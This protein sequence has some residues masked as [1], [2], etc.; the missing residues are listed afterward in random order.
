MKFAIIVKS[1]ALES[2][3]AWSAA[4]FA[5]AALANGHQVERIFFYQAAV[6]NGNAQLQ[7]PQGQNDCTT[8]WQTLADKG[9]ELCLCISSAIRRGVMDAKEAE[10]YHKQ[11]TLHPAFSIGGLGQLIDAH[12]NADRVITFQ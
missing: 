11:S 9:V 3:G 5:H 12:A 6:L 8:H 10:R 2:Q 1:S 7:I 4:Q